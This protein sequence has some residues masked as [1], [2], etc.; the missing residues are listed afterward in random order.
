MAIAGGIFVT[1]HDPDN[2][3]GTTTDRF[4]FLP[5]GVQVL[6]ARVLGL[7]RRASRPARASGLVG[8]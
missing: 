1:G 7:R 4:G 6:R 8:R 2:G 3:T 5:V